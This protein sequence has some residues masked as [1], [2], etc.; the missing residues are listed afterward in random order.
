M[1]ENNYIWHHMYAMIAQR[2]LLRCV[3][4]HELSQIFLCTLEFDKESIKNLPIIILY[5]GGVVVCRRKKSRKQ[6]LLNF[7]IMLRA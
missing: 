5:D 2:V 1:A 7:H 4:C 6:H 3:M